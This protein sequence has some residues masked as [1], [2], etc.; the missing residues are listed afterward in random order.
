[1]KAQLGGLVLGLDMIWLP[2]AVYASN[3]LTGTFA[4]LPARPSFE[5]ATLF[6]GDGVPGILRGGV[7][8]ATL[9]G[10]EPLDGI[11]AYHLRGQADGERLKVL[12][13][14]AVVAGSHALDIWVEVASSHLR[15]LIAREPDGI[16]GWQL[17][18]SEFDKPVEIT[19]P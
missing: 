19:A 1:M 11:D 2:E 9:L 12:T 14:G 17:D 13:G 3:P 16:A 15:R 5:A 4:K 7:R 8:D 18:L 10:K 6:G